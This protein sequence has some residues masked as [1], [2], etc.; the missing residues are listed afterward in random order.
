MQVTT[1]VGSSFCNK[2]SKPNAEVSDL[3]AA[4]GSTFVFRRSCFLHRSYSNQMQAG[5]VEHRLC[6]MHKWKQIV[7]VVQQVLTAKTVDRYGT[8]NLKSII[9]STCT[10]TQIYTPSTQVHGQTQTPV[11]LGLLLLICR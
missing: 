6:C 5:A 8:T 11:D 1:C 10:C 3:Y 4:N 7:V 9:S 2:Q